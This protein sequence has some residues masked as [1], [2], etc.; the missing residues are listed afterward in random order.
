MRIN[1]FSPVVKERRRRVKIMTANGK[2]IRV[3]SPV[4]VKEILA[5]H[6][7]HEMFEAD[8]NSRLSIHSRPLS[9]TKLLRPGCLYFLIH[10]PIQSTPS[11]QAHRPQIYSKSVSEKDLKTDDIKSRLISSTSN[12][13]TVRVTIRLSKEE[14]SSLL[15][16]GGNKEMGDVLAPLIE[17]AIKKKQQ[18]YW[19]SLPP[20]WKP[21]L[22]TIFE[23]LSPRL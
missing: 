11:S 9:P 22:E 15:S 4:S 23:Q 16:V 1:C 8:R 12:G 20:Q 2:V 19:D 5:D 10:L 14:A 3:W 17:Q 7:D 18:N 13:S 6:P 21:S